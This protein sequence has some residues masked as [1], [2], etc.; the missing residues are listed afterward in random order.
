[1][2]SIWLVLVIIYL[3]PKTPVSNQANQKL[4]LLR[5]PVSDLLNGLDYYPFHLLITKITYQ[6]LIQSGTS[7]SIVR[8]SN[9]SSSEG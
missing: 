9:P 8:T 6:M 4:G 5:V 1:M 2:L 3:T 7:T